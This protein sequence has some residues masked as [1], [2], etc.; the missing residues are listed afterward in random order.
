MKIA[1]KKEFGQLIPYSE[2]DK[3]S[4]DCIA[5]GA[6]YEVDIKHQDMRTLRQNRAFWKWAEML[7][8]FLN[9]SGYYVQNIIKLETLWNKDRVK[10]L[11]FN[12]VIENMGKKSSTQLNKK[13]I[14]E[15]IDSVTKAFATKGISIPSFPNNED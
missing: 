8:E 12:A 7:S 13:E 10:T 6:V 11:I 1:L 9:D 15:L 3:E 14:D 4:L 5:D 2:S